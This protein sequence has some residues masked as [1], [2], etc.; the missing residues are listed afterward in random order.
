M[1]FNNMET[2]SAGRIDGLVEKSARSLRP[3]PPLTPL[4]RFLASSCHGE[5]R[6]VKSPIDKLERKAEIPLG[7]I[8]VPPDEML[9]NDFSFY[10]DG[11]NAIIRSNNCGE[12]NGVK[13][14]SS[15]TVAAASAVVKGQWTVEEDRMLVGLVKQHGVR[16]WSQIAKK[17]VG[18]SGKQ[19]RERW[20]NH[21]RPDIKKDTWTEEEERLLVEAHKKVGNRWAEI[22]KHIPGRSENSIKNHWNATRRRQNAK[23]RSK[24]K[25]AQGGRCRPSILHEYVRSKMLDLR[26]DCATTKI[27]PSAAPPSPPYQHYH[28]TFPNVQEPSISTT[29]QMEDPMPFMEAFL[30]RSAT[31]S[32]EEGEFHVGDV[33]ERPPGMLDPLDVLDFDDGDYLMAGVDEWQCMSLAPSPSLDIFQSE[34]NGPS[35]AVPDGTTSTKSAAPLFSDNYISYLLNGAPPS[36]ADVLGSAA[37]SEILEDQTSSSCKRELDLIEMLSLQSSRSR[38]RSRSLT[39]TSSSNGS[40]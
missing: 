38:S 27:T 29:T 12:G 28:I 5:L 40:L 39:Q 2:V 23:R 3:A 11:K 10:G 32:A 7:V 24:R 25:T 30:D 22:A 13:G 18:R 31:G 6:L 35:T 17:L 20:H 14:S 34:A 9:L 19:C 21:L 4:Q 8:G 37:N 36:S 15:T 16:K 33:Q 1:D 26:D